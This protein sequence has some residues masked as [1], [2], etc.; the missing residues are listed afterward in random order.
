M[1]ASP[2]PT[3]SVVIPVH[4]E[5]DF[6]PQV[7]PSLFEELDTVDADITVLIAENGSSDATSDL[8]REA[9]ADRPNLGLL[10]LP[11]P[12]YGAAM[13]DGFLA[14][15]GDWVVNFDIDYF[16]GAFLTA[17]LA[18]RGEADIVLASK[19]VEGSKDDRGFVRVLAT[20]AF[21]MVLKFMLGSGVSDTHGMKLIRRNVVDQ[22][23]PKVVSTVDLFD[24]E[25]VVRAEQEGFRIAEL[26]IE[27]R[28]LRDAK[29][30]LFKRV[31]RT[32]KGVWRI[33]K[34]FRSERSAS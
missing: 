25:L 15:D 22:I 13:R 3:I 17:A 16:S 4:N 5:A 18:L 12:N 2:R 30:S 32:L 9:M 24:T 8:V 10:E 23:V 20:W 31:P 14:T 7:L 6:L 34:Q 26:P 28:E 21:N 29:S 11:T 33:R 19:R 27:V 1:P